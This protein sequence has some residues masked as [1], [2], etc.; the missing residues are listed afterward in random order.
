MLITEMTPDAINESH[1]DKF[2]FDL[3]DGTGR[4]Q[5]MPIYAAYYVLGCLLF[6][7]RQRLI[8]RLHDGQR[9]EDRDPQ[10]L[11]DLLCFLLTVKLA[12]H[13]GRLVHE[14]HQRCHARRCRAAHRRRPR[15]PAGR[16][17]EAHPLCLRLARPP[18]HRADAGPPRSRQPRPHEHAGHRR[19][20][21]EVVP[22]ARLPRHAR[23]E[24]DPCDGGRVR[25]R[26]I[27]HNRI[28]V[29]YGAVADC[30][31]SFSCVCG[32]KF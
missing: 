5:E 2:I 8:R 25:P 18:R 7:E 30:G 4:L 29:F 13:D 26:L 10:V 19:P 24:E 11:T 6:R 23:S 3:S 27:F 22:E 20:Q 21:L 14:R 16:S 31:S 12:E 15:E 28:R 9:H 1:R 32:C 17:R